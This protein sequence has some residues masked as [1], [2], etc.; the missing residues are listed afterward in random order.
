VL[1]TA[2]D[3]EMYEGEYGDEMEYEEEMDEDDED[4]I[5][6]EDEE[7]EAMEGMGPIEGL[8]GDHG[9]DVEVIM[10]DDEDDDDDDEGSS[11][12]DDDDHDSEDDDA[13]VEIIDEAGDIGQLGEDDMGEWESDDEDDDA[14]EEDYEGQAADQEEQRLRAMEMDD[15]LGNLVRALGGGN[16]EAVGDMIERLE[17]GEMDADH[18]EDHIAGEYMEEGDE[19]GKSSIPRILVSVH[20]GH[21]V[22]NLFYGHLLYNNFVLIPYRR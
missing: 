11:D 9:V 13:R 14:E 17:A 10:E 12:D 5:S 20:R 15:P 2:D 21:R 16:S 4:N 8:S 19:E 3:E 18:D 1:T 22:W 6:D 7:I